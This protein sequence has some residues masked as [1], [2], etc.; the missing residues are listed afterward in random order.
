MARTSLGMEGCAAATSA[1]QPPLVMLKLGQVPPVLTS[2]SEPSYRHVTL[3]RCCLTL[4]IIQCQRR[5]HLDI[6]RIPA[7]F[8]FEHHKILLRMAVDNCQ[9]S[10]RQR[11]HSCRSFWSIFIKASSQLRDII[12]N[13]TA[14]PTTP[15]LPQ[16]QRFRESARHG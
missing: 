15:K 14:R 13:P 12:T 7:L 11:R 3:N 8:H 10:T 2:K 5:A 4:H 16:L 6:L 1:P 9:I